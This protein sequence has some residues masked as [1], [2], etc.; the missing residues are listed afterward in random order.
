MCFDVQSKLTTIQQVY[1]I[2]NELREY[3]RLYNVVFYFSEL[4]TSVQYA[5]GTMS[6][7]L[8]LDN[9]IEAVLLS[10]KSTGN[11]IYPSTC[12]FL[13]EHQ[14][15]SFETVMMNFIHERLTVFFFVSNRS[16][17]SLT[18]NNNNS[19]KRLYCVLAIVS[20]PIRNESEV[21]F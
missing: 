10:K 8:T 18:G 17:I 1:R 20:C 5:R 12:F 19:L 7:A 13:F 16:I 9:I 14:N 11:E 15:T 3:L 21:K 4:I 6:G 2:D